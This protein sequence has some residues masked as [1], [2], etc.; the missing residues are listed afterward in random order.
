MIAAIESLRSSRYEHIIFRQ[1][2]RKRRRVNLAPADDVNSIGSTPAAASLLE[3]REHAFLRWLFEQAGLELRSYRHETLHRRLAACLRTLR[4]NSVIEARAALLRHPAKIS[5]AVGALVI[6]VT[7]LF[8]DSEVFDYLATAV[9]PSLPQTPHRR[10]I[11]SVGCSDGDEVYSVAI[12]LSELGLLNGTE[13][14]AT[15]CRSAA[16]ANVRKAVYLSADLQKLSPALLDRY[17][18]RDGTDWRIVRELRQV[19]QTRV[20]DVTRVREPGIWDMIFCRNMAM[21]L[22][23]QRWR[24]S[25]W[26]QPE[27]SIRPGGFLVLGKAERPAGC[28]RLSLVAPCVYRRDRG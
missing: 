24:R 18:T 25:L 23:P 15:D 5:A 14:L 19:V 7:S 28:T 2:P 13:L 10:R 21:Y 17:F 11:W 9:L 20:A 16:I 22:Q 1:R 6:G 4:V 26:A 27:Q 12:Q 8:R 3:P